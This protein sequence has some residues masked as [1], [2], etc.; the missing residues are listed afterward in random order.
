LV[1]ELG[2]K[3]SDGT[4]VY[5]DGT[6]KDAIRL[7]HGWWE[8]KDEYDD[9]DREIQVKLDKGYPTENILFEDSRI[10]V[11]IQNGR[12]VCRSQFQDDQGL[13][14]LISTF[15]SYERPE[16]RTFRD[17]ID[18]FKDDLP[19]ILES[20]RAIVQ[21][22]DP[23]N[24]EFVVQRDTLLRVA[25]DSINPGITIQDIHEI[26]IQ[27][28]LTEDIFANIFH[29]AQFHRDNNPEAPLS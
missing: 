29:D 11:L 13:D 22:Q 14:T 4:T 12:E 6:I 25:R 3:T 1:P 8:S 18:K 16:V 21:N 28:I 5:P 17:A 2:I 20:L 15:D 7:D 26:I 19:T 10:A 27:H 23:A 9:L 24:R